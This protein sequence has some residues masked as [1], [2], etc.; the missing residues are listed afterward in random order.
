MDS[1]GAMDES[2]AAL[3]R[4]VLAGDGVALPGDGT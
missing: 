2:V 3:M 4:W 1:G